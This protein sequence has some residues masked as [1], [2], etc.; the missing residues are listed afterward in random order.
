MRDTRHGRH[1]RD[2]S[3]HIKSGKKQDTGAIAFF[4]PFLIFFVIFTI[5]L[6]PVNVAFA[7]LGAIRIFSGTEN[8]ADMDYIL[9]EDNPF[10]DDYSGSNRVNILMLGVNDG[11][12]DT[13]ML[14][15]YNLDDQHVDIISVPRDTYYYRKGASGGSLKINSIYAKDGAVGTAEAVSSVLM[16]IP[17]NY[18]VV[19]SYDAV[20]KVVDAMGGVPMEIPNIN[21]KGGM[22]YN[23]PY[24]TPPLKIALPA[25]QQLLDGKKAIQFLRFRKGYPEGDIGR[26]KA[27]QEFVK[28]AFRQALGKDL[29]KVI[30]TGLANVDSDISL[31][32]ATK[33][34]TSALGLSS[35]DM[36][37]HLTPG[38]SAMISGLSY[39]QVDER[40]TEEMIDRIYNPEK[41]AEESEG[42]GEG[43][44]G[45]S[46]N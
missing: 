15:S 1:V 11:L 23:D 18:Y 7:K 3:A 25:G 14:G 5:L 45:A 12:T 20:A 37:T 27:Q 30:K 21:G 33:L 29:L 41:Y 28:S 32:I 42:T 44:E 13:I 9:D 8:L 35:S 39:W 17:I 19:I 22:Y 10:Y 2:N 43:E 46:S 31:G 16:D 34:G 38:T 26:V 24:D 6:I 4:K 40:E 36:E